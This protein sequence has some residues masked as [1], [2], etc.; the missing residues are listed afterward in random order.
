MSNEYL[1]TQNHIKQYHVLHKNLVA[2]PVVK[3]GIKIVKSRVTY[4][5]PSKLTYADH[6]D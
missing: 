1:Y 6:Y 3:Q 2:K 5:V 4:W